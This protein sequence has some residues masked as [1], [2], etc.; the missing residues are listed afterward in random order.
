MSDVKP[1]ITGGAGGA[2]AGTDVKP[3]K[4]SSDQINLKVR[5]ADGTEIQFKIKRTTPMKKLMDAYAQ[6]RVCI[7]ASSRASVRVPLLLVGWRLTMLDFCV[8][9]SCV[10][11]F[12]LFAFLTCRGVLR[13]RTSS[14][15]MVTV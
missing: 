12:C 1:D 11:F 6:R 13:V 9:R 8:L 15:S 10:Y 4:G 5:D 7:R 2:G 14:C 3:D